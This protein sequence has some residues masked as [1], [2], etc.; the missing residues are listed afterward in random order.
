MTKQKIV[1][2]GNFPF[3]SAYARI[4][5]DKAFR[6]NLGED[7]KLLYTDTDS[8]MLKLRNHAELS[9][10][11]GSGY[12]QWKNELPRGAEMKSYC[13]LG[14]KSYSYTYILNGK[15]FTSIKCKGFS[16]KRSL[17][18]THD[19]MKEMVK[20]RKTGESSQMI[21][22]QFN[23]RIEKKSRKLHNSFFYKTLSSDILKKRVLLPKRSL[24]MPYGYSQ[25]MINETKNE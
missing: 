12:Y 1:K 17:D 20:K 21:L 11:F 23:I 18:L 13:A 6:K 15:E 3:F 19:N 4:E 8:A 5:M 22:P 7:V 10:P 14:P 16:L 9:I 2:S 24:T 25:K